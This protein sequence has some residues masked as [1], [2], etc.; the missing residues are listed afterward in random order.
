VSGNLD[1]GRQGLGT[2]TSDLDLSAR[3]VELGRRAGVV[4]SELLDADEVLAG[5][6][7][8]RDGDGVCGY[9]AC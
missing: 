1:R 2:T 9:S 3:D 7:A 4:D 6:N 5:G 8:R